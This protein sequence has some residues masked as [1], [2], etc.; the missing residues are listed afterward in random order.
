M[1]HTLTQPQMLAIK[2]GRWHVIAPTGSA[3]RLV[4]SNLSV[5]V[6]R[7]DRRKLSIPPATDFAVIVPEAG[8]R[9]VGPTGAVLARAMFAHT[10]GAWAAFPKNT[11]AATSAAG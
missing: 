9:M 8:C 5:G 11:E 7:A 6:L 10:L 4:A 3:L 1:F 2:P